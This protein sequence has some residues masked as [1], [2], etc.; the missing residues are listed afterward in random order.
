MAQRQLRLQG[1]FLVNPSP[2]HLLYQFEQK[3]GDTYM[4][5]SK[6]EVLELGDAGVLIQNQ[7]RI[8]SFEHVAS[9]TASSYDVDE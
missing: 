7:L 6:P 2:H 9:T 8:G 1:R 4:K 3:G 5:Y